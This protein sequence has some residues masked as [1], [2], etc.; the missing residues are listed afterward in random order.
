[1]RKSRLLG[2]VCA[3]LTAASFN[4]SAA[5]I[6][7]QVWSGNGHTY[8]MLTSTT[9]SDAEVQAVALG[10]HL[11]TIN[12]HNEQDWVYNT[13]APLIEPGEAQSMWIGYT[14]SE[15]FGASEGSWRW[16]NGETPS[17]VNWDQGEPNNYDYSGIGIGEDFAF[18]YLLANGRW[19]D[20]DANG[21]A[22]GVVEVALV[23]VPPA[24]LLF[25]SGL[26]GLVEIAT[27][28]SV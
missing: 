19:Y 28:K 3:C 9:W 25:G 23:P 12:N 15:L 26:L 17:Y 22:F 13:F 27:K 16:I 21:I 24:F 7:S 14:D 11:V 10:G 18:M 2:A 4:A 6:T 8:Y 1:V 5:V 20:A